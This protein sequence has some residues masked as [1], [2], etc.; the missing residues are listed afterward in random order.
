MYLVT[1][2]GASAAAPAASASPAAAPPKAPGVVSVT[3]T[4]VDTGERKTAFGRTARHVRTTTE[5]VPQPGACD[6]SKPRI[7]TDGWYIDQ[8]L[9]G[10]ESPADDPAPPAEGGCADRVEATKTGDAD[11]LGFPIAYTTTLTDGSTKDAPVVVSMEITDLDVAPLDAGLFD[12][13]SGAT[14]VATTREWSKAI[15]DANEAKLASG[16][17][18]PGFTRDKKPGAL[19]IGVPEVAN[20]TKETVDTRAL[21]A[22]LVAELEEQKIEAVPMAGAPMTDL[23]SRAADLGADY[24]LLAEITELKTS[25][26][27]GLTKMMRATARESVKD[28]TEAKLNV[29]LVPSD[30]RAKL[31]ATVSAKD[32]GVG[33]RT[34][35]GLAKFAGSL[36]LRMYMGGMYGNQF[37]A[38]GA[39]HLFNV[40]GLGAMQSGFGMD[41]TAMAANTIMQQVVAAATASSES[42]SFDAALDGAVQNAGK[43]V[44]DALKKPASAKK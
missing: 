14:Q 27:G 24:L 12:I 43:H 15:S 44:V 20:N 31:S 16:A 34:G 35:L 25:K 1:P 26:A 23:Q 37:G 7:E 41:R 11:V 29:S 5:R 28:I 17:P 42:S 33:L 32:G 13:P 3:T 30:G 4:V 9:A 8:P 6:Q 39:M 21:R 19:R 36:Y 10:A 38:F 22:R 18:M 40:S 2:E